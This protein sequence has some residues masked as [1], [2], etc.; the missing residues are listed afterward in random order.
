MKPHF[1]RHQQQEQTGET[2][3]KIEEGVREFETPEELLR[4]DASQAPLPPAI[5]SRLKESLA[6]EPAKKRPWWRRLF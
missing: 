2:R 6:R 5:Q 3:H 4:Y 1:Q